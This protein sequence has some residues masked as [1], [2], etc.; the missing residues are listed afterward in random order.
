MW[1]VWNLCILWG[2]V[3]QYE[4]MGGER[5]MSVKSCSEEEKNVWSL[6]KTFAVFHFILVLVVLSISELSFRGWLAASL[7]LSKIGQ[8]KQDSGASLIQFD[9]TTGYSEF[10]PFIKWEQRRN[11][12]P[13]FKSSSRALRCC[14]I[15]FVMQ[16][17]LLRWNVYF[18]LREGTAPRSFPQSFSAQIKQQAENRSAGFSSVEQPIQSHS[19]QVVLRLKYEHYEPVCCSRI[20]SSAGL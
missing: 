4:Q 5:K 18:V 10:D 20:D 19:F 7:W 11:C 3:T 14:C 9:G 8:V 2:C 13:S 17:Q 15:C 16:P 12:T 1:I 6:S